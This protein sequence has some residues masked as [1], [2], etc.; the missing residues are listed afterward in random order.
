[1]YQQN[2][3]TTRCALDSAANNQGFHSL[4]SS[5][6]CRARKEDNKRK[7]DNELAAKNVR[8]LGPDGSRRGIA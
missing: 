1:M 4:S 6:H 2:E 5:A 8:Q 3:S 7:Q